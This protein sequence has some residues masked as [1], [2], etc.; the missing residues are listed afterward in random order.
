MLM[1]AVSPE[2]FDRGQYCPP[3]M[4][5]NLPFHFPLDKLNNNHSVSSATTRLRFQFCTLV[6]RRR[7]E[8]TLKS[9]SR[10][11]GSVLQWPFDSLLLKQFLKGW[12]IIQLPWYPSL[13]A[14]C[15]SFLT[16]LPCLSDEAPPLPITFTS[17]FLKHHRWVIGESFVLVK[18]SLNHGEVEAQ[19][20]VQKKKNMHCSLIYLGYVGILLQ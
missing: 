12:N 11:G 16:A 6:P 14:T 9:C 5:A 18:F 2:R 4:Q 20:K 1:S 15:G 13:P 8:L 10:Q 7:H 17:Y 3:G 19:E